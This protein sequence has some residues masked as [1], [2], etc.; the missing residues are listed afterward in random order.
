MTKM[1]ECLTEA[2]K[3]YVFLKSKELGVEGV[4][5]GVEGNTL[6]L[7]Q[8]HKHSLNY[9]LIPIDLGDVDSIEAVNETEAAASEH[10]VASSGRSKAHTPSDVVPL[11]VVEEVE[12]VV[13]RYSDGS[14]ASLSGEEAKYWSRCLGELVRATVCRG[15]SFPKFDWLLYKIRL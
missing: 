1:F 13:L 8:Y 9:D 11:K 6:W 14:A 5:A 15:M 4:F 10:A 3:L 12:S 2:S 7:K